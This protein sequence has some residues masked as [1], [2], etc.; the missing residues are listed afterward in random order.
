[1]GVSAKQHLK[2]VQNIDQQYPP[3]V[4]ALVLHNERG[5]EGEQT[6]DLLRGADGQLRL[7][8][9]VHDADCNLFPVRQGQKR[10]QTAKIVSF[11]SL[12]RVKPFNSR[13]IRHLG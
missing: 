13:A 2:P 12:K 8:D 7:G 4:L 10:Q 9:A 6:I 3:R 5:D 11:F 1:M